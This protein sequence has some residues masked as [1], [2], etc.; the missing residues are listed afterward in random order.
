MQS[1]IGYVNNAP[2]CEARPSKIHG[3]GL[4]AREKIASGEAFM[5]LPKGKIVPV[6]AYFEKE[7]GLLGDEW[8]A[9]SKKELLVR[10]QRTYYYFINHQFTPN[11][12]VDISG[13]RVLA[14][15]DIAPHEEIT[16]DYSREPLP[17]TY[18]DMGDAAYLQKDRRINS[19]HLCQSCLISRLVTA[20]MEENHGPT[21]LRSWVG[22][23]A[24]HL[25]SELVYALRTA[26]FVEQ[27]SKA[28]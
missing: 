23:E 22:F 14:L 19:Q 11:G 6:T 2:K 24:N 12:I 13:M 26:L 27:T 25:N 7:A 8:N 21:P 3:I 20:N 5:V 16:L 4:F 28:A 10:H 17:Q 9:I 1:P 18:L 15:V